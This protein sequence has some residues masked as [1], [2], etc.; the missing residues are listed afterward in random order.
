LKKVWFG[1]AL[2]WALTLSPYGVTAQTEE[3][4][5]RRLSPEDRANLRAVLTEPIPSYASTAS[6]ATLSL[7]FEKKVMAAIRLADR[8]ARDDVQNYSAKCTTEA[9]ILQLMTA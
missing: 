6:P 4:A 1:I 2:G 9:R 8:S 7:F 3:F 5:F